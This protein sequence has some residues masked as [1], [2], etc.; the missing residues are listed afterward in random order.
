MVNYG[1]EQ[2]VHQNGE[3]VEAESL[4]SVVLWGE[5]IARVIV[6]ECPHLGTSQ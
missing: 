1:K 2:Q 6:R 5:L 3:V 4:A